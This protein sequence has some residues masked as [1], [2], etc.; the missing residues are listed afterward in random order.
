MKTVKIRIYYASDVIDFVEKASKV[1]SDV[2]VKRG[3]RIV[4][5]TSLVGM[6]S[7][8]TSE[9]ITVIYPE[10]DLFFDNFIS[11]FLIEK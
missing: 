5:G 4:D 11:K 3:S 8:N 10:D 9:G 1:S 6:L 2:I 7:L